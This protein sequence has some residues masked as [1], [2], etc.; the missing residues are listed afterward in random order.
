MGN[1]GMIAGAFSSVSGKADTVLTTDG[2]VL[3]YN[4]GRQR[5]AIGAEGKVLTV[6]SSDLP[7]WETAGG[8]TI[9]SQTFNQSAAE[10]TT[11]TSF[12]ATNFTLTLPTRSGGYAII[13]TNFTSKNSGANLN[14]FELRDDAASLGVFT[15]YGG[16]SDSPQFNNHI[17]SLDG[18]VVKMYW[19]VTAGTG[20]L[21]FSS[22]N[23]EGNM[24]TLEIS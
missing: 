18:S 11:S 10:T 22:T 1:S 16:Q 21:I 8:A 12:V 3:Y 15:A 19:K 9:S 20:T 23:V 2:D 4:S 14:Y 24:Q 6:S 5:L 17:L 13:T 7:A